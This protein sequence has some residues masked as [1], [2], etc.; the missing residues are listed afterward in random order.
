MIILALTLCQLSLAATAVKQKSFA[1][2]EE[3][4]KAAVDRR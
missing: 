1:T 4:V 3:A 2:P